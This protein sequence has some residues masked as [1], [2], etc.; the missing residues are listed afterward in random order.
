MTGCVNSC[1]SQQTAGN[2]PPLH[3]AFF[4]FQKKKKVA[5]FVSALRVTERLGTAW[6]QEP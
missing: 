5:A 1:W 4:F 3:P 6:K 2:H